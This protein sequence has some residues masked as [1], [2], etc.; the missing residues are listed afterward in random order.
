[1]L[2]A[3]MVLARAASAEVWQRKRR[4]AFSLAVLWSV[5]T[6]ACS[7]LKVCTVCKLLTDS[8]PFLTKGV[9]EARSS[10]FC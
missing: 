3:R 6:C 10:L 4:R 7:D 5:N 2:K 9:I 8:C 1:M